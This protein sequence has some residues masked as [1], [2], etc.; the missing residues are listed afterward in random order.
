MQSS[1]KNNTLQNTFNA[2]NITLIGMS[3][4]LKPRKPTR[5]ANDDD[6]MPDS[7]GQV[8]S[9]YKKSQVFNTSRFYLDE[10]ITWPW[11]YRPLMQELVEAN[12][13]DTV[14][15]FFN[16]HG[17]LL[18][19]AIAI[20]EA[21]KATKGK[22]T[23]FIMGPCHSAA[24]FIALSCHELIVFDSATMLVH[25]ASHGAAGKNSDLLQQAVFNAKKVDDFLEVC[26][27]GF[28]EDTEIASLKRGGDFWFTA[29]EIRTRLLKRN[30]KYLETRKYIPEEVKEDIREVVLE[31]VE[32][33]KPRKGIMKKKKKVLD[34]REEVV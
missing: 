26:Y 34:D 3:S 14:E 24:S 22:V 32:P 16:S 4:T 13:G 19:S 12:E 21:I 1:I 31:T 29:E 30:E 27:K 33:P 7:S 25:T 15:L 23:A 28:L 8:I 2:P 11:Y 20:T 5:R 6:E 10:D 18:D 9:Y 17:G